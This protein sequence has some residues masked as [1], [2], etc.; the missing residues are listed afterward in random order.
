MLKTYYREHTLK[1]D[2][3]IV[4]TDN[5]NVLVDESEAN[6]TPTIIKSGDTFE[7]M[8]NLITNEKKYFWQRLYTNFF[9]KKRKIEFC[10]YGWVWKEKKFNLKW[11]YIVIDKEC[12]VS[13]KEFQNFPIEKVIQFY[14]ER[15]IEKI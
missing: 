15:G 13:L 8:W 7:S 10:Q 11:E 5:H 14:K 9:T 12:T 2:D 6:L 1:I 4:Y 3:I